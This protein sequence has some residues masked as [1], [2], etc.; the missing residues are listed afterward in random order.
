MREHIIMRAPAVT[1]PLEKLCSES[2]RLHTSMRPVLL[3]QS[4]FVNLVLLGRKVHIVQ[5]VNELGFIGVFNFA[6]VLLVK[7]VTQ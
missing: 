4:F 2:P 7:R 3:K 1:P 6:L 5:V